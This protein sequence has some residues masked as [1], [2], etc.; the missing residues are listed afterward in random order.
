MKIAAFTTFAAIACIPIS[1]ANDQWRSLFDGESLDG[2]RA[3]E[4]PDSWIVENGAIVAKGERSHLFYVGEVAKHDFKNFEF[5]ADVMTKPGANSGIYIHTEFQEE[6]WPAAGYELQ[7]ANTNPDLDARYVE[8]KMTGSIYAVRNTWQ[9]PVRDNVWFEYRIRVAGKTVQT[10]IDGE[11][12]CEYTEPENPWRPEDKQGRVLDSGTFA[13]QAHD[14]GSVVHYRNIK[15]K[16]LADNVE[17]PGEPL[18]DRE[19]D[20]LITRLSNDNVPLID[21]GVKTSAEH[22]GESQARAARRYGL[23]LVEPKLS[24][25]P[26]SLLIINDR[27]R[28]PSEEALEAAKRD[29]VKLVFSSGGVVGIDEDRLKTRLEAIRDSELGWANFWVPGK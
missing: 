22:F 7:V 3:N 9:A 18:E 17:S 29:A 24:E 16:L 13:F 11:L 8:H 23:T 10:F 6:G 15:V 20:R 28:A 25:M 4:N 19:L 1:N 26:S 5:V 2:W 14:S 21:I 12:I 27:H